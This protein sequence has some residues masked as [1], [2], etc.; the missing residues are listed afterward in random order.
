MPSSSSK[1]KRRNY[2]SIAGQDD[3]GADCGDFQDEPMTATA[4]ALSSEATKPLVDGSKPKSDD[5]DLEDI[6]VESEQVSENLP[7]SLTILDSA[8][9]KF[10]IPC[11][12]HWTVGKFKRRSA[13]IHKVAPA[14]Q[15]LIFRGK[16]LTN[17]E[18]TLEENKLDTNDLIV[19]LFPKPRVVVTAKK[20]N[21]TNDGSFHRNRPAGSDEDGDTGIVDEDFHGAHIPSIVIDQ[22]EQDRR[23]Q[24]LVLGSVEIAESQNNVKMLSLLLVMI[25]AMRLLSLFSIA[26]GAV[27][28]TN[29]NYHGGPGGGAHNHTGD[30]DTMVFESEYEVRSWQTQDYFDLLVSG[31]GFY[32]GTLGMKATQENTFRLA[33]AY[34]I[35]TVVAGIGW[36][37][38]NVYEYFRFFEEQTER[39][40][41]GNDSNSSD[42][43]S[44]SD[45]PDSN[46][47]DYNNNDEIPLTRDDFVTVAFFTILMPLFVWFLCCIRAFEFRRLIQEAEEEAAERIR[48]EYVVNEGS[49]DDEGTSTEAN[50]NNANANANATTTEIV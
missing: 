20:D 11:D 34:A 42:P 45:Y 23:G 17:D 18:Q 27:D 26:M 6:D 32:V 44:G 48:N 3:D 33:S 19:H 12:K 40:N 41:H 46:T 14:Q 43:N 8:Q 31:I 35:G 1:I 47:P 9:K 10:P 28:E 21:E 37:L 50:N 25:C 38:W 39:Q 49:T 2:T 5:G 29:S 24:I 13:Q 30:D 16:M 15:R 7:M 22:D 4:S 36:N